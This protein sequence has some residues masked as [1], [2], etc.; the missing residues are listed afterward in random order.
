MNN[1]KFWLSTLTILCVLSGTFYMT[2][3]CGRRGD[4]DAA[5]I[6]AS[7]Q[8]LDLVGAIARPA[9]IPS[10]VF[11]FIGNAGQNI[12]TDANGKSIMIYEASGKNSYGLSV[13]L[14]GANP[15]EV[16]NNTGTP[17]DFYSAPARIALPDGISILDENGQSVDLN[18]LRGKRL[19]IRATVYTV[20]SEV[21]TLR[22]PLYFVTATSVQ[23]IPDLK[24]GQC[25]WNTNNFT[26]VNGGCRD[27]QTGI[28]WNTEPF[29]FYYNQTCNH[30]NNAKFGGVTNWDLPSTDELKQIAGVNVGL[31]HFNVWPYLDLPGVLGTQMT[32]GFRNVGASAKFP[33]TLKSIITDPNDF[34][35]YKLVAGNFIAPFWTR[36]AKMVEL[37]SGTVLNNPSQKSCG[38]LRC[39]DDLADSS[40]TTARNDQ[41]YAMC[42]SR[43]GGALPAP[44]IGAY[45]PNSASG[46]KSANTLC[47]VDDEMFRSVDS[48]GGCVY[49]PTL[50][51]WS[52]PNSAD[53]SYKDA[54]AYC[55][56]L[57]Q[58][59]L[60]DWVLPDENQFTA[61]SGNG[62]GASHFNFSTA[63][64]AFWARVTQT[65][66]NQG[67]TVNIG[68]GASSILKVNKKASVVCVR[69]A[70]MTEA[71]V[72]TTV[73]STNTFDPNT[74]KLVPPLYYFNSAF[75]T[76][77]AYDL[78]DMA[79]EF[80]N[81]DVIVT[82]QV[83]YTNGTPNLLGAVQF[84]K[85]NDKY[86]PIEVGVDAQF[87][88]FARADGSKPR[89]L[90]DMNLR[91]QAPTDLNQFISITGDPITNLQQLNGKKVSVKFHVNRS[92]FQR[93]EGVIRATRIKQVPISAGGCSYESDRFETVAE[94]CQVDGGSV[95]WTGINFA[96]ATQPDGT[97]PYFYASEQPLVDP[98]VVQPGVLCAPGSSGNV[99][100]AI[101]SGDVKTYNIFL[102]LKQLGSDF[103]I[104]EKSWWISYLNSTN[105]SADHLFPLAYYFP[106]FQTNTRIR[107]HIPLRDSSSYLIQGDAGDMIAVKA[108]KNP[109]ILP[110]SWRTVLGSFNN[111]ELL[112]YAYP[113][114]MGNAMRIYESKP[115]QNAI[116][117][118]YFYIRTN[119]PNSVNA[120]AQRSIGLVARYHGS[121]GG[122]E[123][124]MYLASVDY[125]GTFSASIS[126]NVN[127]VWTKLATAPLPTP[128]QL[129]SFTFK[130][131]GLTSSNPVP[132][133]LLTF[134]VIGN[135]LTLK[136]TDQNTFTEQ[137]ILNVTD[138][139][140]SDAG[141]T[142]IRTNTAEDP[143]PVYSYR[144]VPAYSNFTLMETN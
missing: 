55:D 96:S 64:R 23:I 132:A 73:P 87:I 45:P 106:D 131:T 85:L 116:V 30:L 97:F 43:P 26:S 80:D 12:L 8:N 127:G 24:S 138:N 130:F 50:S 118:T 9:P 46:S 99:G 27:L 39:A 69:N 37:L 72:A 60:S 11:S 84:R 119:F 1:R 94:G 52:K 113:T 141:L 44:V 49:T 111:S 16:S 42:I 28:I 66:K 92:D 134:A 7:N 58:G 3:N 144:R 68:T 77:K 107:R 20:A 29:D 48:A 125:N 34:S 5:D 93:T 88:V 120:S 121:A 123:G 18:K 122:V 137:T 82:G 22:D 83:S 56:S 14:F 35:V 61:V 53:L 114:S 59:S 133:G 2:Q 136:F 21:N 65:P 67:K 38:P 102:L 117:K 33:D 100:A 36:E 47:K 128:L 63:N 79:A 41:A 90:R 40:S 32:P 76:A 15:K 89:I 95:F 124:N 74:F 17:L 62:K 91:L 54:L 31:A 51:T 57:K 25:T 98:P 129:S 19:N 101:C 108:Q 81:Q 6:S 13:S 10:D 115:V 103:S 112:N 71:K 110:G 143:Y 135:Q 104:P 70:T 126:R 4:H 142:G 86:I 105:G 109:N 75:P 140:I 139:S 78:T